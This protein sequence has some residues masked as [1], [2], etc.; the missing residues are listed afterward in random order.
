MAQREVLV[1]PDPRL[2]TISEP[3]VDFDA[4]LSQRVDDLLD[5][6]YAT[7]SAI[8][9]SAPQLGDASQVL[10][11]DLSRDRSEPQVYINPRIT[12]RARYGFVEESCLSVPEQL[13]NVWRATQVRVVAQDRSGRQFERELDQLAAVCLQHEMDHFK[14]KLLVDRMS[15]LRRYRYRRTHAVPA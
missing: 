2:R 4:A 7:R 15:F 11:M 12:G 9:L 13:V 6:L 8:G 14:G 3:V 5:T 10:V 1:Y